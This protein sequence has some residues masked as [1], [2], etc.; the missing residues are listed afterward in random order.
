MAPASDG[1]ASANTCEVVFHD[2]ALAG[3]PSKQAALSIAAEKK[4]LIACPLGGWYVL[5]SA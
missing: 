1:S 3:P 5:P 4:N 2:C